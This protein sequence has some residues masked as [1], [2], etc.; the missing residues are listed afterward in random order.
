LRAHLGDLRAQT[1]NLGLLISSVESDL[2]AREHDRLAA[3]SVEAWLLALRERISEVEANTSETYRKRRELVK[4]L[5]EQITTSRD[6]YGRTE[7]EVR[8]RF[9]PPE[10]PDRGPDHQGEYVCRDKNTWETMA[11]TVARVNDSLPAE[12]RSRA[13]VF[14]ANYG[15]AG[16]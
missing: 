6:E 5:V 16:P 4:L 8:Y 12:D 3:E 1:D 2:A 11:A 14:T 10:G 7:I 15:E 9:G 13:C